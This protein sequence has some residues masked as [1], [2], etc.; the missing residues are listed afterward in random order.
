M[1]RRNVLIFQTGGLG[2]F[3]LTWPFAVAIGR[4]Y[5][6]SRILYVSHSQKGELAKQ[7]LRLEATDIEAGWHGLFAEGGK[8]PPPAMSLLESA[9]AVYSFLPASKIWHENVDRL[10]PRARRIEIDARI[11]SDYR[12][13]FTDRMIEVLQDYPPERS[14]TQQIIRSINDRGIGF[15]PAGGTDVVIHPGS[16]SPT[17]YWP[18]ERYIELANRLKESGR[19]VRF[20]IGEVELDRWNEKDLDQLK[21]TG[22]LVSCQTYLELL[23]EISSAAMFV[24]NDSGPAHLAGIIG[25]PTLALFGSTNP[26]QWKPLGPRVNVLQAASMQDL[27][28]DEVLK[29]V[30][31]V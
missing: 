4:I 5:P 17:K 26:V 30:M 8:L 25:V 15:K 24:G 14:A 28:V 6:Q 13:H 21:S 9:H 12:G 10:N 16:G 11:T 31:S 1:L 18:L 23:N 2:D 19:S 20:A 29:A 3:V 22:R 7:V 27:K